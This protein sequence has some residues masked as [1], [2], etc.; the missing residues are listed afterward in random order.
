MY[1]YISIHISVLSFDLFILRFVFLFCFVF[2]VLFF[3][4]VCFLPSFHCSLISVLTWGTT[5]KIRLFR[6]FCAISANV[7]DAHICLQYY[8]N[9]NFLTVCLFI[10]LFVCLFFSLK[11][12]FRFR[13]FCIFQA[14]F[15]FF[16]LVF[17]V[18]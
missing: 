8:F 11:L 5:M 16:W 6:P 13:K 18:K 4:F 9:F 7:H 17:T 10:C 2:F 12:I 15:S 14:L 1:I 3:L